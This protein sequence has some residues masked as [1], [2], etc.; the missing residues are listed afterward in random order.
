MENEK[1]EKTGFL[2]QSP[3]LFI[4]FLLRDLKNV[5]ERHEHRKFELQERCIKYQ[6]EHISRTFNRALEQNLSP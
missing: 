5:G 1:V 6:V 3:N 2:K 4:Y